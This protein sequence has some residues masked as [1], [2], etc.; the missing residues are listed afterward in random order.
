[1]VNDLKIDDLYLSLD[2]GVFQIINIH[3][4]DII[5]VYS[6]KYAYCKFKKGT[7]D[8]FND[9]FLITDEKI[10]ERFFRYKRLASSI[11]YRLHTD[12]QKFILFLNNKYAPIMCVKY[13]FGK[14]YLIHIN[15]EKFSSIVE[16]DVSKINED[17][18]LEYLLYKI[19]EIFNEY[20]N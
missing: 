17:R 16:I 3:E 2:Y 13:R 1:M 8:F 15:L 11:I 9:A 19:E 18:Y 4:N 10:I 6:N 5:E 7:Y 12:I 20:N 14:I